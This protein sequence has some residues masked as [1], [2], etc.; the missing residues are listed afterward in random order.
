MP[1]V[2]RCASFWTLLRL[3]R[4]G[5]GR[6]GATESG[7]WADLSGEALCLLGGSEAMAGMSLRTAEPTHG[8]LVKEGWV[9]VT[10]IIARR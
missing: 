4:A 8:A 10:M 2:C 6:F 5:G 1:W 3:D 9:V 7:V